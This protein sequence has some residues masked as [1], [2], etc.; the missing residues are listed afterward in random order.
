M[1][2]NMTEGYYFSP[3][4]DKPYVMRFRI[5]LTCCIFLSA[6]VLAI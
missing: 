4:E 3:R 6:A 2:M 1:N 5:T